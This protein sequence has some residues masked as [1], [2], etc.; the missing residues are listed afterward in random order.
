MSEIPRKTES[1]VGNQKSS[2]QEQLAHQTRVGSST[3][4][5]LAHHLVNQVFAADT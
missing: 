1:K 2:L 4:T 3:A 5:E